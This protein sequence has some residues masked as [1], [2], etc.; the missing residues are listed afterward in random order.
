MTKT[1][2]TEFTLRCRP[3]ALRN[4]ELVHEISTIL[5]ELSTPHTNLSDTAAELGVLPGEFSGAEAL[6]NQPSQGFDPDVA[7]LI[8]VTAPSINHVLKSVWDQIILPAIK[9][10]LGPDA[11]GKEI[12]EKVTEENGDNAT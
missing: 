4:D 6:I 7:I 9:S 5:Q 1:Y 10:R 2:Q 11:I 8:T 3:G 12:E